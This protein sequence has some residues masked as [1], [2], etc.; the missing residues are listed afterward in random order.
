M[1]TQQPFVYRE[2][3]PILDKENPFE[4]M[5]QRFD[6]AAHLLNL[7]PGVYE[8]LKTPVRQIIVSIPIAMDNGE[9]KVFEGFRVIHNDIL[10]PSKGGIRYAPDV[11]LDE[12][13]ALAAWM[14]WKCAIMNIPF[15]GAKGGV[16]CDPSKLSPLQLEK[17]TRRYTSNLIDTF[18]PDRDVP[19]P[20]MNT[21]EQVMAWVMDTY[22]MHM[23]K[24]EPA[25]VTGK[26][27]LLGGSLGRR[28]AT[29]R[30]CMISALSAMEKLGM[31]PKDTT[32]VVQGFGNVGSITAQLLREQGCRIVGVGDVSGAFYNKKGIDIEKAL[33]WVKTNRT[34]AGF[35]GAEEIEQDALLELGC[36]VL[37]PAAKEDQITHRN[38]GKIKARIIV[39]GANG[40][41]TAKADP[42][43]Q[44]KG[45]LVVPDILANAGG[46]T[47]SYFEWVQDRVGYFWSLDRVNGRLERMMKEAFHSVYSTAEKYKVP[48]RIGAYILAIDKVARTLKLRGIYA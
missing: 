27:L 31:K 38:A 39:E 23:R 7:E 18:G 22:S 13:K 30:G 16:R 34:L 15:G 1:S 46:V 48:L 21:N 6:V 25:V 44:E 8:Y 24:T 41:T 19:A 3:A 10:G 47:V 2:P 9:V 12:M 28:E 40:P 45:I 5:M 17:I 20:D 14:T 33:D 4:S 11:N 42:I 32:V 36:D 37:V 35:P 43:L 29:G 26:P